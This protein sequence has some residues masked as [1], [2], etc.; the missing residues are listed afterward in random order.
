MLH[1][2]PTNVLLLVAKQEPYKK[3]YLLIKKIEEFSGKSSGEWTS[4]QKKDKTERV[5]LTGL[6]SR[7]REE[8]VK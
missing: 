3:A 5:T 6:G 2:P 4:R 7:I 8:I 1:I